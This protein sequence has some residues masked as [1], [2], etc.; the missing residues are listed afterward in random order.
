MI[1]RVRAARQAAENEAQQKAAEELQFAINKYADHAK[2]LDELCAWADSN[3]LWERPVFGGCSRAIEL[4]EVVFLPIG[5]GSARRIQLR[6]TELGEASANMRSGNTS[7]QC[8]S[9]SAGFWYGVGDV[10]LADIL[11]AAEDYA[12]KRHVPPP[13]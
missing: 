9:G 8:F 12:N 5:G 6:L 4:P 1:E 7:Y 3:R 10:P 13:A 2:L 11:R